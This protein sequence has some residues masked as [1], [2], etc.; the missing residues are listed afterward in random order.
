MLAYVPHYLFKSAKLVVQHWAYGGIAVPAVFARSPTLLFA[1]GISQIGS[2]FGIGSFDVV[3]AFPSIASRVEEDEEFDPG[4]SGDSVFH[5]VVVDG[6]PP[7]A[8]DEAVDVLIEVL[9]VRIPVFPP[10]RWRYVDAAVVS[11]HLGLVPD[12][13]A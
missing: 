8:L 3:A 2:T 5:I 1:S 13:R 7:P 10:Y 9:A 11:L 4:G 6:G 12:L